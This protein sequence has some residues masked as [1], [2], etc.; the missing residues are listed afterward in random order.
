MKTQNMKNIAGIA[1]IAA[2]AAAL[3]ILL[4]RKREDGTT[5]GSNLLKNAKTAGEDLRRFGV[6]MK[7]RLMNDISGPNG[8][9]VYSD[10]YDRN[11]YEDENGR[12][13]YLESAAQS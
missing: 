7:N 4:L 2:G 1:G 3:A 11:F 8:E 9:P 13:V 6:K 12:R 5:V 10:M